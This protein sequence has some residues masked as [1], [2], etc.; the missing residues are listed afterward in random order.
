MRDVL[1][2][3]MT[4]V[5]V[6]YSTPATKAHLAECIL[7]AAA[8]GHTTYNELVTAGRRSDSGNSIDVHLTYSKGRPC[9]AH[10]GPTT[11]P[12]VGAA[13][14]W[15][16]TSSPHWT[17]TVCRTTSGISRPAQA[18]P[19]AWTLWATLRRRRPSPGVFGAHLKKIV[20]GIGSGMCWS[21]VRSVLQP[22]WNPL[23]RM[24][25]ATGGRAARNFCERASAARKIKGFH[26]MWH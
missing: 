14:T 8:Q 20:I 23:R 15:Q 1:E 6:K 2:D 22:R 9:G 10:K 17:A 4:R 13:A 11:E 21:R 19:V 3:V 7:K 12:P 26:P 25:L 24:G 5:P 16:V 18:L